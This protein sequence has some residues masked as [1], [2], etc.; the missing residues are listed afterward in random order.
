MTTGDLVELELS[1][2]RNHSYNMLL[3][4]ISSLR[5]QVFDQIPMHSGEM[6][7]TTLSKP[8]ISVR[9]IMEITIITTTTITHIIVG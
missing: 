8:S 5:F 9:Q 3:T 4:V 2:G 6:Y 7:L 1:H